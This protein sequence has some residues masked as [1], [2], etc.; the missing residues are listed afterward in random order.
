MNI[1]ALV[2][3]QSDGGV[4]NATTGLI[5]SIL[6]IASLLLL[7]YVL[8]DLARN[9]MRDVPSVIV[10]AHQTLAKVWEPVLRPLRNAL[11]NMGGLDFSPLI[12]LLLLQF[13][14]TAIR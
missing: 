2:L 10:T 9:F 3:A 1:T 6:S 13:I 12:V 4:G 8:L 7:V 5:A 14:A 11:P